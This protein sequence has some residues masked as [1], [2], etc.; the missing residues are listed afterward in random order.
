MK[1]FIKWAGGKEREYKYFSKFIP[2]NIN[3]Y[4]EPFVGGGAVYF[5]MADRHIEGRR[6]INDFSKELIKLYNLIAC[7]DVN[8]I[9]EINAIE[10]NIQLMNVYATRSIR[11]FINAYE[12][13]LNG[14]DYDNQIVTILN[15]LKEDSNGYLLEHLDLYDDQFEIEL[16]KCIKIKIKKAVKISNSGVKLDDNN[17]YGFYETALKMSLY[18]TIRY[19]YNHIKDITP[20]KIAYF[21]YLREYC[22]SSMFRYNPDGEFNVPY[23]GMSYNTKNFQNVID[24]IESDILVNYL[25]HTTIRNRDF[26]AFLNSLN[27][28]E[29][30]FI[31]VDPPY[32]SEFSEYA[33]NEFDRNDQIRLAE[34]LEN[35]NANV[36]IVIKNTRFINHLYR[37]KGFHIRRFKKKYNVNFQNRNKREVEHLIITNYELEEM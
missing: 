15:R 23:G 17:L 10:S 20:Y 30:D 16:L 14:L 19:A 29:N 24:Y 7:R 26:E 11:L 6:Y 2:D 8:F 5:K 9:N 27:I 25:N 1:P 12:K 34:C 3:N 31:F 36:M 35:I 37:E 21:L 4:I 18:S 13:C 28:N 33:Q 22:Y 32:D